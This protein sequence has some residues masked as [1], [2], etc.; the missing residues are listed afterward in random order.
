MKLGELLRNVKTLKADFDTEITAIATDSRKAEKGSVFFCMNSS[1]SFAKEAVRNGAAAVI[2]EKDTGENCVVVENITAAL[3]KCCDN[4]SG[5]PTERL[6]IIGITGTNGKTTVAHMVKHIFEFCGVRTGII[7]TAGNFVGQERLSDTDFTT[8]PPEQMY[9]LFA[10]M[11][12]GNAAV[13]VMETS[14]QALSQRRCEGLSFDTVVFTNLTREHLDYHGDMAAYAQAKAI[15]FKN[16]RRA[17]I[18]LDDEYSSFF[19]KF[20][21][22]PLTYSIKN[23]SAD[24]FAKNISQTK[25]G[26]F[27]TLVADGKEFAVRMNVAGLFNVSNSLAAAGCAVLN[28]ISAEKCAEALSTFHGV[29]G[30]GEVIISEPFTVLTDY[31]HTP[32]A[33]KNILSSVRETTD[34]RVIALLGCGGDRDRTKRPLMAKTAAENS[35]FAVITS[36]NPRTENPYAIIREILTGLDGT[37]TP[38][39]VI[40]DR[41][42]AIHFAL[43]AAKK[44]DTVVL[45]G[46]GHEN[47]QII[48]N[49]KIPFDE[50]QIVHDAFTHNPPSSEE[51]LPL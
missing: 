48:G 14:S 22:N 19:L 12:Q 8:P 10:E 37:D 18:N 39:A 7:G 42:E 15:L 3:A 30:R 49:E 26:I 9:P 25:D 47:Y 45:C 28:E 27:Y 35:D 51:W 29:R 6:K 16:S 46:K 40:E 4:F 11:V 17:V 33:L 43:S 23:K 13:C 2:S 41:H 50:K 1:E 24:L 36:D 38:F 34:G 32:D 31:A 21:Q 20:C 44:G 5:N